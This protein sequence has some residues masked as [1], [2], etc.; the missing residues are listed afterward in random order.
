MSLCNFAEVKQLVSEN[1]EL[2]AFGAVNVI[3]Q[4]IDVVD[5]N[6]QDFI[7]HKYDGFQVYRGGFDLL[8][9]QRREDSDTPATAGRMGFI[10]YNDIRA[11][12]MEESKRSPQEGLERA[13]VK[14]ADSMANRPA[15]VI[16]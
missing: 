2:R 6:P 16:C 10:E 5:K 14:L 13:A 11:R 4:L 1:T 12:A 8:R 7:P 3:Q 15:C 9:L